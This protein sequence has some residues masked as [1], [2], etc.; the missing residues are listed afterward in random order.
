MG[1][2]EPSTLVSIEKEKVMNVFS[3]LLFVFI[4]LFTSC[5]DNSS[6]QKEATRFVNEEEYQETKPL[7]KIAIETTFEPTLELTDE[8]RNASLEDL[9]KQEKG[10]LSPSDQARKKEWERKTK[11][12]IEKRKAEMAI[13]FRNEGYTEEEIERMLKNPFANLVQDPLTYSESDI[14][15]DYTLKYVPISSNLAKVY[16]LENM[17][18]FIRHN[19][20]YYNKVISSKYENIQQEEQKN[21][22]KYL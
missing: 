14:L 22:D 18:D 5:V 2:S 9:I 6:K 12:K 8:I 16:Y 19:S 4:V 17:G 11:I 1:K 20:E 10:K 3:F 15:Y 13:Q 21:W 7:D